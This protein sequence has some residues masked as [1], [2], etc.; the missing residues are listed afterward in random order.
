MDA[1]D[2]KEPPSVAMKIICIFLLVLSTIIFFSGDIT[3]K[4]VSLLVAVTTIGSY[5]SGNEATKATPIPQKY[6]QMKRED[7]GE[8]SGGDRTLETDLDGEIMDGLGAPTRDQE[9][10]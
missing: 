10:K 6:N 5:L 2:T 8:F 4:I 3:W 9:I 1:T 7:I